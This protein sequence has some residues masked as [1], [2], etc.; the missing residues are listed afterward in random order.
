MSKV[1]TK[2]YKTYTGIAI[3]AL[4]QILKI[5]GIEIGEEE[6]K[7]LVEALA[8]TVGGLLAIYGRYDANNIAQ[9]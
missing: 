3:L 8:T 5:F 4:P 1:T 7:Q 9:K 2:G 6:T